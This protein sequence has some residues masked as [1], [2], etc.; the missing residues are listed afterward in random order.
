MI[1][2]TQ[3]CFHHASRIAEYHPGTGGF[4]HQRVKWSVCQGC[5]I[6]A[7]FPGPGCGFPG[8]DDLVHIPHAR[9]I[10]I[11]AGSVHFFPTDFE[12]LCCTGRQGHIDDP[13]G[14]Q[15]QFFCKIRFDRGSLHPDGTFCRG[16]MREQVRVI[17]FRKLHPGGTAGRE[18]RQRFCPVSDA[19]HQ[20]AGF[21][22]D[23]HIGRKIRVQY[24]IHTEL[25]QH[26]HHLSFHETSVRQP[27]F[28]S[29]GNPHRGRRADNHDFVRIGNGCFHRFRFRRFCNGIHGAHIGT[30]S[31]VDADGNVSRMSQIIIAQDSDFIPAHI[32]AF[33]AAD[34]QGFPSHN[35]RI[36]G[37]D[38]NPDFR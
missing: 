19:V 30:L 13:A 29:Q 1:C 11:F 27:E 14:I 20:F 12:F 6:D 10:P 36:P 26:G 8:R 28:F 22:Q 4:A 17:C 7:R 16:Q 34:T 9:D 35:G 18:L 15:P 21:F 37:F 25:L 32:P 33:P 2:R 24:V 5:E 23:R 31:A 3:C 38:G